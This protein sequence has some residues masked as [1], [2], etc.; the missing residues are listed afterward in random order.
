V[1]TLYLASASPAR[2][3]TLKQ[4]GITP[5]LLDH[6]VNEHALVEEATKSGP[7]PPAEM[8][9]LLA[10]AKAEDAAA[11]HSITG[12]VLGGDSLFEVDGEV[13]G[14]P[15]TPEVARKRWHRQK[16][17]TG[18]LHSGHELLLCEAGVIKSRAQLST[19]S[20]VT[21]VD[22]LSDHEIDAYIASGEPLTV[23]GAFTIDSL[24]AGFIK[25]IEGDPYTV[26]GLS[27]WALRSLVTEL[28]F[29][30]TD[31]WDHNPQ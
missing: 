25:S 27:V 22:D 19:S 16:G 23:A 31:L 13:F 6:S 7:V 15:H 26:V 14:K 17:K 21:F 2:L 18:T 12:L 5:Q 29:S 1:P 20:K 11:A 8:V 3:A 9:Q 28:G 24:G 10:R 30:Y 4:V